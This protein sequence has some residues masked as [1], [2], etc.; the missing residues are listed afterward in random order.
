MPSPEQEIISR[1]LVWGMN[2]ALKMFA[3]WPE[4]MDFLTWR[5]GKKKQKTQ[6]N[7]IHEWTELRTQHVDGTAKSLFNSHLLVVRAADNQEG[8]VWPRQDV[9]S[10]VV[11]GDCVDLH[12][13]T[14]DTS[15]LNGILTYDWWWLSG[16]MVVL[17]RL[18]NLWSL[19]TNTF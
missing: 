17:L 18:I 7:C 9:F 10:C 15:G 19:I 16:K 3:R 6:Q 13:E 5:W 8:V 14:D 4:R 11:P 12:R 1:S 2:L